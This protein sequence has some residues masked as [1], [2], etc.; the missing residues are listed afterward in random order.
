[1]ATSETIDRS[2]TLRRVESVPPDATVR[3][4][5]QLE[6]PTLAWFLETLESG[7]TPTVDAPGLED[8]EIIVFTACYRFELS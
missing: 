1:M 3:H 8:G 2:P 5:D 7:A 4:I 6:E